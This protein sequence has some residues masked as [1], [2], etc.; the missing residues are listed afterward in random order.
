M[1]TVLNLQIKDD[2]RDRDYLP[3]PP[4]PINI[5]LPLGYLKILVILQIKIFQKDYLKM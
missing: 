3:E 2:K 1:L 5:A 4:T